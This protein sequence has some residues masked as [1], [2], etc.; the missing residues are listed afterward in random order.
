MI[1][2]IR[3]RAGTPRPWRRPAWCACLALLL[4]LAACGRT[5][6]EP[7]PAA[8]G[9]P[10]AVAAPVAGYVCPMHP[11]VVDDRPG[12]CPICGMDL[13]ERRAPAASP[14]ERR[15][16]YWYDPMRPEVHFDA[17]GRSPFMDMDLVPRYADEA[18][19]GVAVDPALRQSL[20]IRTGHPVRLE[21]TPRLRVAARVLPDAGGVVRLSARSGGW[22]ERLLPRAEGDPVEAGAVVAELYAPELVQAQNE[23]LLGGEAAS[24]G[25]ERLSRLGIAARDIDA[26][27]AAGQ[28]RRR[29]PLR[30]PV[31][32]VVSRLPVRE[33]EAVPAG[34]TVIE[35]APRQAL[36]IEAMLFPA[37]RLQLGERV[38]ARF[39]LP[40]L[41]GRHWEAEA[42]YLAPAV[43][44]V[45]QTLALRFPLRDPDGLLPLGAW[46]DAEIEGA[47]HLA[48]VAVPAAAVIRSADGDRVVRLDA[49][50]RFRP[51][52][53]SI[54]AIHDGWIEIRAGLRREDEIVL[55][56]Q[57]LLDA[58]AQLQS[59]WMRMAVPEADDGPQGDH[60]HGD[61]GHDRHDGADDDQ[62][63][64]GHPHRERRP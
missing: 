35:L 50:G 37:Q 42:S 51:V 1:A 4:I 57:F 52:A 58:E 8:V 61:D 16:L 2:A 19:A 24:A 63:H 49:D 23:L 29:L 11:Q 34:A 38:R 28:P 55:S 30:A 21:M 32:G 22:I 53:V 56:G 48:E 40:G 47:M 15:I 44:P 41:S 45:T 3:L 60:D 6:H 33:G 46:L 36:W 12:T 17:P 39:T 9:D 25:R 13:V 64:H 10:V 31:A 18:G 54:G 20:G 14:G 59:G 26:V 27:L 43:D 5:P 62:A 7:H